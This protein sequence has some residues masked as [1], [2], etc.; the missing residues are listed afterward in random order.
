MKRQRQGRNITYGDSSMRENLLESGKT[1]LG[2]TN[3]HIS[4]METVASTALDIQ[5]IEV[6]EI[7]MI[8]SF[9]ERLDN[10]GLERG[11]R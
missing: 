8:L 2:N 9:M 6:I 3:E 11:S 5:D 10:Q 1:F 4:P 7:N